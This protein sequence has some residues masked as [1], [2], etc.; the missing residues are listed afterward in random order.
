MAFVCEGEW[1]GISVITER[2][3]GEGESNSGGFKKD[4]TP[5]DGGSKVPLI[6]DE[7]AVLDKARFS[8]GLPAGITRFAPCIR[9]IRDS[10][11]AKVAIVV[12]NFSD[13]FTLK[14]Q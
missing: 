7:V 10:K 11:D 4:F 12:Q 1:N 5:V 13:I 14:S 6:D 3:F 2:I 9:Y 8:C